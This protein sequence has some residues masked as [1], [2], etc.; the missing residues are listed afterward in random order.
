MEIVGEYGRKVSG[1][2]GTSGI[3]TERERWVCLRMSLKND[4]TEIWASKSAVMRDRVDGMYSSLIRGNF[5]E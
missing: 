3:I 1:M 4:Q 2:G 5:P